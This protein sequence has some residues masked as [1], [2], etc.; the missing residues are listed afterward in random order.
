[1]RPL[2][3]LAVGLVTVLVAGLL[4]ACTSAESTGDK[5]YVSGKGIITEIAPEDRDDPIELAG[6][7]LDGDPVDVADYHGAPLVI[8]VWG[9]WCVECQTEQKD[10]NKAAAELDGRVPVLGIDVRD[11]SVEMAKDYERDHEVPYESIDGN[12]G[13]AM[14]A[15]GSGLTNRTVPAFA[16][17]DA[18]G[19]VAATINGQLPST[20]TLVELAESVLDETAPSTPG[21]SGADG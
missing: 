17:L 10:V 8:V 2:R 13:R 19:R 16:I 1:M 9:A 15:F 7:T 12:D 18:E 4:A 21:G 11:P 20:L 3:A 14:L 5:G 6:E